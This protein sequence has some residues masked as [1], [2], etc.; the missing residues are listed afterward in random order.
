[1]FCSV[2]EAVSELK[3]LLACR[4]AGQPEVIA[5]AHAAQVDIMVGAAFSS[6]IRVSTLTCGTGI[7]QCGLCSCQIH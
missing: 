6:V 1:V 2:F 5:I 3:A 7:C 4:R